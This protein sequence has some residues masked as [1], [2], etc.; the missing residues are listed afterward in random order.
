MNE[1]DKAIIAICK[2]EYDSYKESEDKINLYKKYPHL[3]VLGVVM[4]RQIPADKAWN[5]PLLVAEELGGKDFSLFL[6][7][8][9]EYYHNLFKNNNYHRFVNDMA[10]LF[11]ETIQK[12][13]NDYNDDASNIWNDTPSSGELVYRFLE[14]NGVGIKL[15][16]MAANLL[17]RDYKVKLKD[18]YAIDISPDVHVKRTM[19]RL[20]Y[21]SEKPNHDLSLITREEVIYRAKS[22]NPEFPGLLDL[23]FFLVGYKK[24]CTNSK[25]SADKCPF[26]NC[27]RK[28]GL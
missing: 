11:Y 17:S 5:I 19:Y 4:D 27:C 23:A 12:I 16:T 10:Q 18:Y 3:Y 8:D 2:K 9:K 1:K 7:K 13:H 22:I 28:M 26:K 20:G 6:S 14:F 21:L 15:A 24:I 25:C